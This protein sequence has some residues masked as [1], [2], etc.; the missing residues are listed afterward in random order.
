MFLRVAKKT[1][2]KK[3]SCLDLLKDG[4][5]FHGNYRGARS[6]IAVK[7]YCTKEG[8]FITNLDPKTLIKVSPYQE[9][10]ELAKDGNLSGA[11]KALEAHPGP[12]RDLAMNEERITSYLKNL[13]RKRKT[14]ALNA[15]DLTSFGDLPNWDRKSSLI[16]IGKAGVGKTELAKALIPTALFLTHLDRLKDFNPQTHGGIIFD[17][18]TFLHLPRESQIHLTDFD[19]PRDIHIRYKTANIPAGTLKIFTSNLSPAGVFYADEAIKRRLTSWE[20]LDTKTI[21][22][23]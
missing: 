12:S 20:M 1:N 17:D 13:S 6:N 5:R 7:K 18:M 2:F 23:Y 21:K 8:N 15:R 3:P 16:I 4:K 14:P 10:R 19:N 9:A 22:I 11:L